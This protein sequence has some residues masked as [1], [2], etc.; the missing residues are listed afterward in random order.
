VW[1][2][3]RWGRA[4]TWIVLLPVLTLVGLAV[5]QELARLLPNLL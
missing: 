3:H 5:S 1:G 4:Q 2:W